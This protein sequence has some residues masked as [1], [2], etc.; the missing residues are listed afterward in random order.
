MDLRKALLLS[1][2]VAASSSCVPA[3]DDED[4]SFA[5]DAIIGGQPEDGDPAVVL[6]AS[7]PQDVS[8][9]ATCTA[10]LIAPDVLLTAAHCVDAEN[11]PDWNFGVFPGSDA[12]AY[13]TAASLIPHLLPVSAVH[14]APNYDHDAPFYADI[15]IVELAEPMT[16]TPIPV[17]F[18]DLPTSL[19]GGPARIIGYGQTVYGTANAQKHSA[20]TVLEAID[21]SDTITVGDAEHR[22]CVGDSGGPALVV[23]DGVETLVGVNSYTD[24]TGCI[25]PAHFRRTDVHAEFIL[26]FVD[27]PAEGGSG[28]GGAGGNGSG[29]AEPTGGSTEQGGGRGETADD[30]SDDGCSVGAVHAGS[31]RFI[32]WSALILAAFA[33]RRRATE[34]GAR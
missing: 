22:T 2:L 17:R 32:G 9:L 31:S 13:P 1:S 33:L 7:W 34:A 14:A 3:P 25:E 20:E 6:L 29:G 11:H 19:V 26:Q 15:A 30:A 18:E 27:P 4:V 21:G 8:V 16:E 28:A 10:T 12:S 5:G 24:T 23:I